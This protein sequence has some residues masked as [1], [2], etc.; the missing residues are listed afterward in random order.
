LFSLGGIILIYLTVQRVWDKKI[1]L[2]SSIFV[3]FMPISAYFGRFVN[4]EAAALFFALLVLYAYINWIDNA[5]NRYF[6]IMV[7]GT[8]LG[9]LIDWPFYLILPCLL[10]YSIITK[11][12]VKSFLYS[13]TQYIDL[14]DQIF[15]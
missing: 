15:I 3:S 14:K 5:K 2:V 10:G 6:L 13:A 7:L 9:G 11:K 8:I 4:F 1:A 12:K